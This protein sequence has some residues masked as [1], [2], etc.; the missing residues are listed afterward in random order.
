MFSLMTRSIKWILF[1]IVVFTILIYGSPTFLLSK[2]VLKN[3]YIQVEMDEYSGAFTVS[4]IRSEQDKLLTSNILDNNHWP[5][6]TYTKVR[7]NNRSYNFGSSIGNI[8]SAEIKNNILF[9]EWSLDDIFISQIVKLINSK[10]NSGI[11]IVYHIENKNQ[12]KKKIDIRLCLDTAIYKN[13]PCF[14]DNNYSLIKNESIYK[15]NNQWYCIDSLNN[16]DIL[17]KFSNTQFDFTD[18]QKVVFS[19]WDNFSENEWDC[20]INKKSPFY[21]SLMFSK[22]YDPAVGIY[23]YNKVGPGKS[24]TNELVINLSKPQFYKSAVFISCQT[25]LKTVSDPF[26]I[27]V[28]NNNF[29]NYKGQCQ[30]I[31]KTENKKISFSSD[32]INIKSL[33]ALNNKTQE[34][35]YSI[36]SNMDQKIQL[37]LI[38]RLNNYIIT[39]QKK[40]HITTGH[41]EMDI[42]IENSFIGKNFPVN[43]QLSFSNCI[44]PKKKFINIYNCAG[45]RIY[46][47]KLAENSFNSNK[48]IFQWNG[49]DKGNNLIVDGTYYY[50]ST[51]FSNYFNEYYESDQKLFLYYP[52]PIISKSNIVYNFPDIN[53]DFDS[54]ILKKYAFEIL[55][56]IGKEIVIKKKKKLIIKGH[57]DKIGQ[58]DYNKKLSL[59][60]AKSVYHYLMGKY[61]LP[62]KDFTVKGCGST[63]PITDNKTN[64]FVNRRVEII[65]EK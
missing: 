44:N 20:P 6:T 33:P 63:E 3:K 22:Q 17:L 38:L 58:E 31:L 39:N 25:N 27:N 16:P 12:K 1:F 55:D 36:L 11:K 2:L 19:S 18:R 35:P 15:N 5:P 42:N 51:S 46:Q 61:D 62:E 57:T 60:R 47:H 64:Q 9:F 8:E 10:T 65:I 40:L 50:Y 53:F 24:V 48:I 34:I 37:N 52:I 59:M 26:Y 29:K 14:V 30:F 43:F 21:N 49:K 45:I 32:H 54:A 4:M 56:S 28:R 7:Y 13:K 23:W 41:P